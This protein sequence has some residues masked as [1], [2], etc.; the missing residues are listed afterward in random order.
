MKKTNYKKELSLRSVQSRNGSKN[1]KPEVRKIQSWL[2]LQD[3]KNSN[4]L[5]TTTAIDG[6]FGPATEMSVKRFQS[7]IGVPENGIVTQELFSL[8]CEPVRVAFENAVTTPNLRQTIINVA[9]NHL[10]QNPYELYINNESNTGPWVRSY[11]GGNEG[12]YWYWCMGFVQAIIDQAFSLHQKNI[13][14]MMP[15]T[16]SC[17]TVGITGLDK[18]VLIRNTKIRKDPQMIKP[19]DILLIRKS[20]YDWTHT[21]IIIEVHDDSILTI[22]GNT[23]NDGSRN[24]DG[25]YMRVRNFRKSKLDVFSIEPWI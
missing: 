10:W 20:T 24:G 19:G 18:D 15:I 3:R 9:Q 5:G 11:M 6:D 2:C 14:D 25:V 8:L 12:E 13:T 16:Y 1:R 7:F 22:E 23:N 17:D 4:T 21:A